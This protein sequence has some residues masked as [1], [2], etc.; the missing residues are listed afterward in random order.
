MKTAKILLWDEVDHEKGSSWP[1]PKPLPDE[2]ITL[3]PTL[4]KITELHTLS[5]NWRKFLSL[6]KMHC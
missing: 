5:L 2:H 6:R 4:A 1:T 3:P